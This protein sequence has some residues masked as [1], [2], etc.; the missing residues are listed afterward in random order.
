MKKESSTH[1]RC[2]L[3]RRAGHD[4]VPVYQASKVGAPLLY[5]VL[6]QLPASGQYQ[7]EWQRRKAAPEVQQLALVPEVRVG[8]DERLSPPPVA[9]AE[10]AFAAAILVYR[11]SVAETERAAVKV[12]EL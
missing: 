10:H 3:N 6:W 1:R 9:V 8:Q 2:S 4:A 7:E 11:V 5:R 12:A